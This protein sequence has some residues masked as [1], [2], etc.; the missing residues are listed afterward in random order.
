ML[1]ML[2]ML[3][4]L[5]IGATVAA[6]GKDTSLAYRGCY[7]VGTNDW[8]TELL[9]LI[10]GGYTNLYLLSMGGKLF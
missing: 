5:E 10:V 2:G 7:V 9:L 3:V 8:N 1:G 6:F 4:T